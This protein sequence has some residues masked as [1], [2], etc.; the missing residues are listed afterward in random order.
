MTNHTEFLAALIAPEGFTKTISRETGWN[1]KPYDQAAFS[2]HDGQTTI[3]VE[4]HDPGDFLVG[5]GH[6]TF[7]TAKGSFSFDRRGIDDSFYVYQKDTPDTVSQKLIEQ[8]ARVVES[9]SRHLTAE[10][11]PFVNNVITPQAKAEIAAKLKAG[12][13]H[14][15][16]PSGFGTAYAVS[17]KRR[18]TYSRPAPAEM[19]KFFGVDRLWYDTLDYD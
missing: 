7:T 18:N 13:E 10:T 16:T 17:T 8:V 11:V 19:A 5:T 1:D 9:R 3:K 15:F 6:T 4:M 2:G 12:K 14:T